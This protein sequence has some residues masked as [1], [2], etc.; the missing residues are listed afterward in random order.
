M[1]CSKG[2]ASDRRTVYQRPVIVKVPDF[3]T[4]HPLFKRRDGG[5]LQRNKEIRRV[6]ARARRVLPITPN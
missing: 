2:P 3:H 5:L 6:Q 1:P 4:A